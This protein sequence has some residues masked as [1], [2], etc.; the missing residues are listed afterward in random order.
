MTSM[1]PEQAEEQRQ[2]AWRCDERKAVMAAVRVVIDRARWAD[3]PD[4]ADVRAL[5]SSAGMEVREALAELTDAQRE[6]HRTGDD[7]RDGDELLA[8]WVAALRAPRNVARDAAQAMERGTPGRGE[9][10][11]R[12]NAYTWAIKTL[13]PIAEAE[14]ATVRSEVA[15]AQAWLRGER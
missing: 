7:H 6:M 9:L 14:I 3:E 1:P 2:R 12:A 15:E 10:V 13:I 11:R 5:Q 4:E 8:D